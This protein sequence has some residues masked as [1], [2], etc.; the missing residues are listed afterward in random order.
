MGVSLVW[1]LLGHIVSDFSVVLSE[2]HMFVQCSF[3][4]FTGSKTE[5]AWSKKVERRTGRKREGTNWYRRS[6]VSSSEKKGSNWE[7]KNPSVLS[8][9]QSK[10]FPCR[11]HF[12]TLLFAIFNKS[13]IV[14]S[15]VIQSVYVRGGSLILA[16]ETQS[17]VKR[18]KFWLN[19]CT[20][21]LMVI[22]F[23]LCVCFC[24]IFAAKAS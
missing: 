14:L 13:Y 5:K 11:S 21:N 19:L 12:C 3:I 6:Q 20:V 17:T 23:F 15:T 16:Q 4:N 9:W 22:N 24:K 2:T 1:K 7:G 18:T 8:D 10:R